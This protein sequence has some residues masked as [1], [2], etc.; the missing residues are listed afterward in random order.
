[1][2]FFFKYPLF[3]RA[4]ELEIWTMHKEHSAAY[5]ESN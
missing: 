2:I 5:L 3:A 4:F 1:M